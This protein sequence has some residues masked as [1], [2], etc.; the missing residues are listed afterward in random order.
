M[1]TTWL[2]TVISYVSRSRPSCLAC[3][4]ESGQDARSFRPSAHST[5]FRKS[6]LRPKGFVPP[7]A[8]RLHRSAGTSRAGPRSGRSS[9]AP[10]RSSRLAAYASGQGG[11]ADG[12]RQAMKYPGLHHRE[13]H[14][15]CPPAVGGM[16]GHV[17]NASGMQRAERSPTPQPLSR[18]DDSSQALRNFA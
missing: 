1:A 7:Y 8:G 4:A 18:L 13:G 9:S 3:E 6:T 14:A 17:L 11:I 16:T 10:L 15:V 5:C 12:G 2:M